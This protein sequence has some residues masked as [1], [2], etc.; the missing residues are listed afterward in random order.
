MTPT[1]SSAT[2]IFTLVAASSPPTSADVA[3]SQHEASPIMTNF[4]VSGPSGYVGCDRE[5]ECF[6]FETTKSHLH[7]PLAQASALMTQLRDC[8]EAN[9]QY[10][11]CGVAKRQYTVLPNHWTS[12]VR[13]AS[14]YGM[15]SFHYATVSDFCLFIFR[16]LRF[17]TCINM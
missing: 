6:D 13:H 16:F 9:S 17:A 3:L 4:I 12:K 10:R 7:D 8:H 14:L 11:G 15:L 5:T 2:D 1:V